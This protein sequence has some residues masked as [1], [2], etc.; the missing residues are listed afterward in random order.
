MCGVRVVRRVHFEWKLAG[1]NTDPDPARV[2]M[3]Q[4]AVH[5]VAWAR[6]LH[7]AMAERRE[8][9][10]ELHALEVTAGRGQPRR[11]GGVP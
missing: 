2:A 6:N 1:L 4:A 8:A 9:L 3:W 10:N 7:V 5:E 11:S